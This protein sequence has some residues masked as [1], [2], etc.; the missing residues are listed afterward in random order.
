MAVA[1]EG[2]PLVRERRRMLQLKRLQRWKQKKTRS[3][4]NT[5]KKEKK[6]RKKKKK[7]KKK[8]KL[9]LFPKLHKP[10]LFK[11]SKGRMPFLNNNSKN[12]LHNRFVTTI[13][14]SISF[15]T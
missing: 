11:L 1:P 4:G 9:L 15:A 6:K 8:K 3:M 14:C 7:K 12:S 10:G 2:L 13:H 5:E